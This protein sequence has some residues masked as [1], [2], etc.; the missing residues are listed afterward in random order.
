MSTIGHPL[1]D[2]TNLLMPFV[3]ANNKLSRQLKGSK[4][5]AQV[6]NA[7]VPGALEGLPTK[8]QCL[9]WYAET[10]GFDLSAAMSWGEAFSVFKGSVIMQGIAARY[11][12]R[13][14]SSE[15]AGEYGAA[16]GPMAWVAWDLVQ[17]AQGASEESAKL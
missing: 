17:Q 16:L 11:A 6:Y 12:V 4:G 15:R 7:F 3:T 2:V 1:A 13:Q 9:A 5:I 10:A 14:A 8:E